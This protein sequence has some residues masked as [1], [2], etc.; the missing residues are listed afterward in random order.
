M[1]SIKRYTPANHDEWNSFVKNAKN[2]SFLHL[3][4]YMDY[5]R[6]RFTDFSLMA[7]HDETLVAVLPACSVEDKIYSHLGLTYGGWIMP[8]KS[9]RA[10]TML[11]VM[12]ASISFLQD[13]GFSELYYRPMPHIYHRYPAEED[14][15]ALFRCGAEIDFVNIASAIDLRQPICFNNSSRNALNKAKR[16]QVIVAESDN[17]AEFW[18]VLNE[19]LKSKYNANPVHSISEIQQ[20]KGLFPNNI[21]LITAT[22]SGELLAGVVLFA[23]DTVIHAQYIA[24]TPL[25]RKTK[26]MPLLVEFATSIANENHR[27]FDLGTSNEQH[28]LVLND[29]LNEQK[30]LLGGRGIA[31]Y[32]YKI[33]L[34]K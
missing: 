13:A 2:F 14:I 5:H 27:Y 19:R 33:N 1:I 4:E 32:G 8:L 28:G 22:L 9:F 29:S 21:R 24:S 25:G 7:Y 30:N 6:D 23:S 26:V 31:Y 11:D 10:S 15:Y 16:N 3:R 18:T 17:F 12:R 34:R 20:L